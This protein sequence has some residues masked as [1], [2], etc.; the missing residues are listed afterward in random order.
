[1]EQNCT[2]PVAKRSAMQDEKRARPENF[3]GQRSANGDLTK[4]VALPMHESR[5]ADGY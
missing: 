2:D 3:P 1:M 5:S 4:I